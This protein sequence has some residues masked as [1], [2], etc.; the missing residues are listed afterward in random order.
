MQR[1]P[2]STR[3]S[4]FAA[5]S[6]ETT[7]RTS[8]I[9]HQSS[10]VDQNVEQR[11][12]RRTRGREGW[13]KV[14]GDGSSRRQGVRE[15]SARVRREPGSGGRTGPLRRG[16]V[17][18]RVL[19]HPRGD[20]ALARKSLRLRGSRARLA[21][22][23]PRV[24]IPRRQS[25]GHAEGGEACRRRGQLLPR[26]RSGALADEA[27]PLRPDRLPRPVAGRGH[28]A[29]RTGRRAEVRVPASAG[30]TARGYPASL[31]R[32]I[33]PRAGLL[34]R[35]A[36]RDVLG[37]AADS[38]PVAYQE[39][40]GARV[41]VDSRY[42]LNHGGSAEASYGFAVGKGY[43]P[44]HALIID[45]GVQYST[46]LGG[47]SAEGG[48]GI[49]VDT[50][51][52]VY[53]VGTT[54]SLDFPATPGAFRTRL[55]STTGVSDVFV[56]K[57]NTS[58]SALIYATYI[59]GSGFDFGRAIAIDGAGN[60]YVTGQTRSSN[61]P[62]TGGAFHGAPKLIPTSR[63]TDPLDAFVTK[64]DPPGSALVYSTS[65]GGVA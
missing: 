27:R 30:R 20:R 8:R 34:R 49:A 37:C 26:H 65:L 23:H 57:L 62:T 17:A 1:R 13:W 9:S 33:R 24:A 11:A 18:V 14:R 35:A 10:A 19:S 60:A 4:A 36:D 7:T 15:A 29:G 12:R 56:S 48:A 31:P 54:Q 55:N 16:G 5:T 25:G 42:A 53:I 6:V 47:S 28:G 21:S 45:P 63:T 43:D 41:P 51:G 2:V 22:N 38:P 40:A 39:I 32:V 44:D 50:A 61:F 52:N 3:S 58:G 46:F 59:G 64:L